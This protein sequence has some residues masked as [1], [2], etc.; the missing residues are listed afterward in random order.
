M[1]YKRTL[2]AAALLSSLCACAARR[3]VLEADVNA[4]GG[5]GRSFDFDP[6]SRQFVAFSQ[7][8]RLLQMTIEPSYVYIVGGRKTKLDPGCH[9]GFLI[10][11]GAPAAAARRSDSISAGTVMAQGRKGDNSTLIEVHLCPR[12]DAPAGWKGWHADFI[13]EAVADAAT[14]SSL[15]TE[16]SFAVS[17]TD[18]PIVQVASTSVRSQVT[19]AEGPATDPFRRWPEIVGFAVVTG[20]VPPSPEGRYEV[21]GR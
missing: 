19:I 20:L 18:G 14:K 3:P 1:G 4:V 7:A 5:K 21:V 15:P 17:A 8:G 10:K 12:D 2:L 16:A 13:I 11:V 9:G 6:A